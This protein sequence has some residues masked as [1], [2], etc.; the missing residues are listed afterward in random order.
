MT[1][2]RIE[3]SKYNEIKIYKSITDLHMKP[4]H[5]KKQQLTHPNKFGHLENWTRFG[6]IFL[7]AIFIS[8]TILFRSAWYC[9]CIW[10]CPSVWC[11]IAKIL[12]AI[13]A[14]TARDN[15]NHYNYYRYKSKLYS[16]GS[17]FNRFYFSHKKIDSY[18]IVYQ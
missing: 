17:N 2:N 13:C 14:L 10:K 12:S 16:L 11:E 5:N 1:N 18:C 9:L 4:I 3:Q 6:F 8:K 15:N 7:I